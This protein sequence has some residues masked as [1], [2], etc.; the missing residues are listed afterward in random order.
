MDDSSLG[1]VTFPDDVVRA[2]QALIRFLFPNPFRVLKCLMDN[3][4]IYFSLHSFRWS[5]T[6]WQKGQGFHKFRSCYTYDMLR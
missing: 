6:S 5:D 3:M 1:S 4:F 2:V